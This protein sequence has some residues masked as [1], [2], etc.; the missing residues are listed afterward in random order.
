METFLDYALL[1][2]IKILCMTLSISL[3]LALAIL[4]VGGAIKILF[5]E[6][7]EE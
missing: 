7:E 4:I 2:P 5:T 1:L 6:G 3:S